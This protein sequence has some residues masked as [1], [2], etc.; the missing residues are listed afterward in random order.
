MVLHNW[1]DAEA[2]KILINLLPALKTNATNRL[3]IMDTILPDPGTVDAV[4]ES[5]M[6]YRDLTMMQ[7]FN[8]KERE[9]SE[10]K[11][12]FEKAGDHEGRLILKNVRKSPGSAL[13]VIEVAYQAHADGLVGDGVNGVDGDFAQ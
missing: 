13:S 12:L 6:R 5:L 9:L 11:D 7:V 1:P 10:F 4:D 2:I 8:T 3:L